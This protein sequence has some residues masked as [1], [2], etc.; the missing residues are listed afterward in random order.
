MGPFEGV[1]S[2]VAVT[3]FNDAETCKIE[4]GEEKVEKHYVVSNTIQN[5]T[6]CIYN[7][8]QYYT[9]PEG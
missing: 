6:N 8:I 4:P 9:G 1:S 5:N 7:T 2:A 3:S